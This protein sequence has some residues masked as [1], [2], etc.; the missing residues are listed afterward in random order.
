MPSDLLSLEPRRLYLRTLAEIQGLNQDDLRW[1]T[2]NV[3][4]LGPD[5]NVIP[6]FKPVTTFVEFI[7]QGVNQMDRERLQLVPGVRD[8]VKIYFF[9]REIRQFTM[10]GF[11]YDMPFDA[12]QESAG[13]RPFA[14]S[15][16]RNLYNE[17]LRTSA[18]TRKNLIVEF[19]YG[20][21]SVYGT[22]MNMSATLT[23][24]SPVIYVVST[25]FLVEAVVVKP[26]VVPANLRVARVLGELVQPGVT[27]VSALIPSR[28]PQTVLNRGIE[29][30]LLRGVEGPSDSL[31][32]VSREAAE[33]IG[34]GEA[35][36]TEQDK[37]IPAPP[38]LQTG[39][40]FTLRTDRLPVEFP[41]R[42]RVVARPK[43][44]RLFV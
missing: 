29:Q 2:I 42:G 27:G 44:L 16:F 43:K 17:K 13:L 19:D 12:R 40:E 8:N 38:Q 25:V 33:I 7:M 5:G 34:L 26:N 18:A 41:K 37:I 24:D 1:L 35:F 15:R 11:V 32:I 30:P 4:P 3:W 14:F 20:Q 31:G 39:V 6:S 36:L 23:S 21:Y 10:Q 22:L 9:D 28:R